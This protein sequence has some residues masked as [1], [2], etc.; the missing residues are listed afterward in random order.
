MRQHGTQVPSFDDMRPQGGGTKL[1]ARALG[2]PR[3]Q[4]LYLAKQ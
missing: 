3:E 4:L 2:G 1:L